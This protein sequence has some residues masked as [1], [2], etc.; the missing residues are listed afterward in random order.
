[1]NG[2]KAR[3]WCWANCS[4]LLRI[5]GCHMTECPVESPELWLAQTENTPNR[6]TEPQ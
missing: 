3:A 2:I 6:R 4:R 5:Y 1:M